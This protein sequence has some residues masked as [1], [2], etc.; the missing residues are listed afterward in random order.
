MRKIFFPT[1]EYVKV[2]GR[3]LTL[4]D[5][6]LLC[7][8]GSGVEFE[9]IGSTLKVTF[10]GDS[11]TCCKEDNVN[12]R[13]LARVQVIIDGRVM[14]DT[15]I[16]KDKE[17]YTVYGDDPATPVE[18]HVV[19]IIKL[20]EPRMSSVAL[21]AIE[22]ESDESISPTA[23]KDVFVEFI[24]DSI[25]CGYGIDTEDELCS[26][27]TCTE[28]ATKAYA[29][30]AA[31]ELDV[32]YSLVS[33]SGHGFISGYTADPDIQN[34]GELIQPYYDIVS[35]SYNK[36]K[37]LSPQDIRWDFERKAN[38]VV[39]NIGTNDFSYT[40][41]DE[42]KIAE[43][44]K[45]YIEFLQKV[46]R[47]NSNAHIICSVGIMGD[48]LYPAIESMIL[49]YVKETGDDNISPLKFEVQDPTV[50]GYAADYHP[51]A[52]THKKAAKQLVNEL[53]KWI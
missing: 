27:S 30:L 11:S 15:A 17:I 10:M 4:E 14:L 2:I 24:G 50:D 40:Q 37:E 49:S 1:D 28:N 3:T 21:G 9:Y 8:S 39:I 25:T 26:F 46:R 6:R 41:A 45:A 52:A 53:K 5:G 12:W 7:A 38:V 16:K 47:Y 31:K 48:E 23:D 43:Y 22:V 29:Y 19:R 20:S 33:Y 42:G 13:D 32:D 36:Y 35:Y 34:I 51:S 44:K 18:H